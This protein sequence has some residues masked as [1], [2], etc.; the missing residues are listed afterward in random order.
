MQRKS[1]EGMLQ[2]VLTRCDGYEYTNADVGKVSG[3]EAV[4]SKL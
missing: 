1:L 2:Y 3:A 4:L